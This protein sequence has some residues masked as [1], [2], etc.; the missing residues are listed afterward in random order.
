MAFQKVEF[1]FPHETEEK[2]EVE[3]SDAVEIDISG[4]KT[5]EDFAEPAKEPS[6]PAGKMDTDDDDL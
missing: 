5:A 6:A 3:A 1:E 2:L 4:K